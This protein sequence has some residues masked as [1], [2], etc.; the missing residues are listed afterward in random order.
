MP[1]PTKVAVKL[2]RVT[3]AIITNGAKRAHPSIDISRDSSRQSSEEP[4]LLLTLTPPSSFLSMESDKFGSAKNA[5]LS[6]P[7]DIP[8]NCTDSRQEVPRIKGIVKC[9]MTFGLVW[10]IITRHY[11][12][13]DHPLSH[14]DICTHRKY[15]WVVDAFAPKEP[16][17]PHGRLAENAFLYDPSSLR[18]GRDNADMSHTAPYRTRPVQSRRLVNMRQ[19]LTLQ[20]RTET[21][22]P[23][24]TSLIFSD[25][26][27]P[28]QKAPMIL[29]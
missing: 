19:S 2:L 18:I 1:F 9:V 20:D 28:S 27:C 14:K 22:A 8:A 4:R 10:F 12:F 6:V 29:S 17:V 25:T 26:N 5:P 3:I 13:V 7:V 11:I 23:P 21:Y 15:A 16:H 24:S